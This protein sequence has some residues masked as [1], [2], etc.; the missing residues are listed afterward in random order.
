MLCGL[1]TFFCRKLSQKLRNIRWKRN[2]RSTKVTLVPAA[3]TKRTYMSV[4]PKG[5]DI[6]VYF[7]K[8]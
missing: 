4:A 7:Y 5:L 3:K 6:K 2:V 8:M 1:Q